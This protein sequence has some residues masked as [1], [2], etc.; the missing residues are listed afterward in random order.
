[1]APSLLQMSLADVARAAG[2]ERPVASMWRKR[3]LAGHTFPDPVARVAG[4]DRFDAF[5]VADYLS[6]TGRG[7]RTVDRDDIVA[8]AHLPAAPDLDGPALFH[9][10][11]ALLTLVA[12]SGA[13]LSSLS[14]A[15]LLAQADELDPGDVMVARE[16]RHLQTHLPTLARYADALADASYS[17]P[18]A[19]EL[20]LRQQV[21]RGVAEHA[22]VALRDDALA[23]VSRA[24]AA[25]AAEAGWESPLF[26]DSTDSS[27]DLLLAVSR[28]FRGEPAAS[29]A[30][31]L[32]DAPTSRLRLRRLRVHDVHHV[33]L[34]TDSNGDL[35][36][37]DGG[38]TG[39]SMCSSCPQPPTPAPATSRS[40]TQWGTSSCSSPTTPGSW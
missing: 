29:V 33:A 4:Q 13:P 11:S 36:A 5:E 38:S 31:L 19:F 9:G 34:T 21:A 24:A 2:V 40:W 17:A 25:L 18:A 23:P 6:A 7:R 10:L 26:V 22:P 15:E 3:A 37:P 14:A 39:R 27:G 35:Q 16:L 20:L 8:H 12:H 28:A 1:M 30:S 32:R